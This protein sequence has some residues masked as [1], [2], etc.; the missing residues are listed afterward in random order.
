MKT[1]IRAVRV[2]GD[3][4][5]PKLMTEG[6]AACDLCAALAGRL[7]G[8]DNGFGEKI[9]IE[10]GCTVL[11]PTGLSAA[12]PYG[13]GGF[14]FARSG[15]GIKKGIT[16]GNCVGVIDSDYRGEIM[17]GLYNRTSEPF[18]VRSGDRIAQMAVIPVALQNWIEEDNLDE[19]N[20]GSGGFGSTGVGENTDV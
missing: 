5:L 3:A 8:G 4:Q 1:V 15:L 7:D 19:T 10:P 9:V 11:V 20:R 17:V 12:I 13:F 16:P 6:S 2:R 14:I 18:V